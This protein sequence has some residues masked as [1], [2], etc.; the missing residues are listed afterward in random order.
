MGLQL[1]KTQQS[2][3]ESTDP[4]W[5][6][7]GLSEAGWGVPLHVLHVL[8]YAERIYLPQ[9]SQ[10]PGARISASEGPQNSLELA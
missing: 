8:E 7:P 1:Y 9:V 10:P 6:L 3:P 4:F 5:V 2:N